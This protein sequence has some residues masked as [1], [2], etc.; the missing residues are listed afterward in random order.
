MFGFYFTFKF[1]FIWSQHV[2]CRILVPRP[3]IEPVLPA[4]EAW[5][6]NH[7]PARA[8]LLETYFK[9]FM[10]C[11]YYRLF[12]IVSILKCRLCV[13]LTKWSSRNQGLLVDTQKQQYLCCYLLLLMMRLEGS[14]Y[15]Q[16]SSWFSSPN[17][18]FQVNRPFSTQLSHKHQ[19][20][21]CIFSRAQ[22]FVT[23]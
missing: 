13:K 1:L 18:F 11:Q 12:F 19:W 3:G 8:V 6:F 7:W 17:N 22:L 14:C 16:S 21:V 15:N 5:S 23:L 20:C 4:V 2:T 10:N 9:I